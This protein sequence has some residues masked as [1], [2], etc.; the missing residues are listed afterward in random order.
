MSPSKDVLCPLEQARKET[1]AR[2]VFANRARNL[3]V[4][5]G[6]KD[7][8]M[9]CAELVKQMAIQYKCESVDLSF[10]PVLFGFLTKR[11]A[12][13]ERSPMDKI[14]EAK[15]QSSL[16]RRKGLVTIMGE[17][18]ACFRAVEQLRE[19]LAAEEGNIRYIML[20]SDRFVGAIIGTKGSTIQRIQKESGCEIE[21]ERANCKVAVHGS[22]EAFEKAQA[23]IEEVLDQEKA[24]VAERESKRKG[25]GEAAAPVEEVAAN[26]E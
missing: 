6:K 7:Q 26:A 4:I 10:S 14:K 24:A 15:C 25:E 18:D 12:K 21:V 5:S 20:P 2:R 3:V 1:G 23:M 19:A 9:K 17:K 13:G 22:P 8:I 11:P 16:D